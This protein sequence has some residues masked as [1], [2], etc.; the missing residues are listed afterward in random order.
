MTNVPVIKIIE[1]GFASQLTQGSELG[2]WEWGRP[3]H[4]KNGR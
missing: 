3:G 1:L 2:W 4:P